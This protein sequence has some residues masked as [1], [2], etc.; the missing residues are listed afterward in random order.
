MVECSDASAGLGGKE[1]MHFR[2]GLEI[3]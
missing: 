3:M 1:T 2:M